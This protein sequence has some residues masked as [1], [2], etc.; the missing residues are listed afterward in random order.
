[1]SGGRRFNKRRRRR[2]N[3]RLGKEIF[4]NNEQNLKDGSYHILFV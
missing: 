3:R 1:M 4:K 2:E